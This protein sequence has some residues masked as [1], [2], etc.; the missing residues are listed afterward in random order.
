MNSTLFYFLDF[1]GERRV[2]GDPGRLPEEGEDEILLPDLIGGRIFVLLLLLLLLFSGVVALLAEDGERGTE[3]GE[4]E[5]EEGE[6]EIE[7]EV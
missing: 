5:I 4:R 7:D 1:E 2:D 3:V 6:R